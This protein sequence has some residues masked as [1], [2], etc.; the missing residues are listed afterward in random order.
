MI[1]YSAAQNQE[2][3]SMYVTSK[4]KQQFRESF[5]TTKSFGNYH[6]QNY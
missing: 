5:V 1:I 2:N 3:F 4:Q 6:E